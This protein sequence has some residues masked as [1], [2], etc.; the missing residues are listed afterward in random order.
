[1]LVMSAHYLSP[2]PSGI[3]IGK[4]IAK[5]AWYPFV[6]KMHISSG[7]V[8]M[9]I[10]TIQIL[11][12][13]L[14]KWHRQLGYIYVIAVGTSSLAALTIAPFSMGGWIN[15][16]GFSCLA[17]LWGTSTYLGIRYAIKKDLKQHRRWMWISYALTFSTIPQRTML[18]LALIT[19]IP[20]I[21]IYQLSAWLPWLLNLIIVHYILP[22]K[23]A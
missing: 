10:G 6:F 9:T 15:T 23:T 5:T 3:L 4:P 22:F 7:L 18:V 11:P 2:E 16:V 13:V 17:I 8:A 1:M 14:R 21:S 20:F 12:N 19:N